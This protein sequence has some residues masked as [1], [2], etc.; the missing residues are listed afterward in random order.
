MPFWCTWTTQPGEIEHQ[1]DLILLFLRRLEEKR[2][3]I[4]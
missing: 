2:F 4:P 3:A 1:G